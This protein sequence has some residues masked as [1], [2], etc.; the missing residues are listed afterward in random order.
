[1]MTVASLLLQDGG[2]GGEG[3]RGSEVV[4]VLFSCSCAD[5]CIIV[6]ERGRCNQNFRYLPLMS[7]GNA[8]C[9]ALHHT[10]LRDIVDT[11]Q[12]P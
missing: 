12:P 8:L 1:M 5:T 7:C 10:G 4:D 3:R 11:L 2:K 6:Y 9:G